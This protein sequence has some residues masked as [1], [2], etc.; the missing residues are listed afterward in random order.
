MNRLFLVR[1]GITESNHLGVYQGQLDVPLSAKGRLQIAALRERLRDEPFAMCYT[2]T[3]C[4]ARASAE[5][6]LEEH[7]CPLQAAA[8][9]DER[10]YGEWEGLTT[11]QVIERYPE[12]WDR[13]V[14]DPIQNAAPGGETQPALQDRVERVLDEIAHT[15]EDATILIAAHG[16]SLRAILAFYL[17]LDQYEIWKLRLDNASLSIVDVYDGGGVL[18][19]FNDT[20]HLGPRKPP[21]DG[22][23]LH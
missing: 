3:L 8:G 20:A 16:G 2:S 1:H 19:L 5:I 17:K 10:D 14:A 21:L 6:L 22:E 13:F 18:S 4:R 9:L 23:P 15:Y 12:A 11:A 7:F